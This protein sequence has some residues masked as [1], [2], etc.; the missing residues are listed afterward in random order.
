MWRKKS[1]VNMQI[2]LYLLSRNLL[3]VSHIVSEKYFPQFK[4]GFPI[5][6]LLVWGVVMFLFEYK[7]HA[8][9]HSLKN[10]MDFIYK[11]SNGHNGWRDFIPF[12]I[13]KFE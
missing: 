8:L 3:A 10:S 11:E 4:L 12:Y 1:N 9:Q 5:T 13:P 2:M 7:P 6:S